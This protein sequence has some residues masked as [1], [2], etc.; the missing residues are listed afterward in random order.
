MALFSGPS[1]LS[2]YCTGGAKVFSVPWQQ[3]SSGGCC[4]KCFIREVAGESSL[5]RVLRQC[6]GSTCAGSGRVMAWWQWQCND[7]GSLM[8][9]RGPR[10]HV[11]WQWKGGDIEVCVCV[12][13]L[14]MVGCQCLHD[15]SKA[16]GAGCR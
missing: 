2:T 3:Q 5:T 14:V 12:Y 7:S 10:I 9:W 11:H 13:A 6:Q 15:S 1:K 8:A 16:V 4:Q